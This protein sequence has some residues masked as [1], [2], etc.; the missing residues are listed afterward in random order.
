MSELSLPS[1]N[2]EAIA[3]SQHLTMMIAEKIQAAGGAISFAE[4]MASVLYT[5]SL[6][7]YNT[8]HC[9]FGAQGDFTTAP[10]L[11]PLFSH[12]IARQCQQILAHLEEGVILEFGAGSGIMAAEILKELKRLD[13]LPKQY[14]IL[15]VSTEL[16][17]RQRT[18]L[19]IHVPELL[20]RIRWLDRLPEEPLQAIVLANEVLDAM[21]VHRFRLETQDILEFYVGYENEQFVWQTLP[22]PN[23][24]LRSTVEVL[25]SFLPTGYVSEINLNLTSWI[26]A[27]ADSLAVGVVLLIDYGFPKNEYYHPQRHQGTLM[28]HYQ[29][30]CHSNPLILAGLQDIT[31]HVNFSEVA[32]A[33]VTASL[34]VAGY[35]NQANFLL[36]CGLPELLSSYDSDTKNYLQLSQQAKTL[37]LPSEMG[38]LFKVIALTRQLDIPLIGFVQDEKNRL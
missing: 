30:R 13:C 10:E 7:Y 34:Q 6:G 12:C 3:H 9:Q 33:A 2:P 4:F 27:I 14:F 21:P 26:Q 23:P 38:E 29:Q 25:H 11:S 24:Q 20:K 22:T 17:K 8:S 1:P 32:E 35:T 31:A 36:A 15:E 5:P 19:Q 28:C 16:Q 18:T 37:V